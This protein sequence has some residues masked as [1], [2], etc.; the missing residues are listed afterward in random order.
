LS[1]KAQTINYPYELIK[2]KDTTVT[3][4]KSQA[5]YLNQTIARQREKINTY[6][7]ETDSLKT[8]NSE[9]DSLFFEAGKSAVYYKF[10]SDKLKVENIKL[11][12]R[13]KNSVSLDLYMGS[14]GIT[15]FI[16]WTN[17]MITR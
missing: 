17:I 3:L 13:L 15:L 9:L 10:E 8:S 11:K 6:K 5:I 1:L 7:I 4:L 14:V 12:T 16:L 2:G